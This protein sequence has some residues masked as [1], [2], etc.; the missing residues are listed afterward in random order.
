MKKVTEPLSYKEFEQRVY[1]YTYPFVIETVEKFFKEHQR[2]LKWL[3]P[4][5]LVLGILLLP[6]F[7]IGIAFIVLYWSSSSLLITELK[8]QLKPNHIYKNIFDSISEDFE[9]ISAQNSGDLD[10]RDYPIASYGVPVMAFKSIVQRSPEFNIRYRENLFSIR[11]LTYEWVETVGKVE[12]RRRQEVAIAKMLMKPNELSDFDF[13]WFQKSLFTRSQN[14][15]TENKQFNSVFAMKSNDP[16]KALMVATPYSMETLLKHYRNNIST[17]LLHLTK[18]RNTFKISF[19]VSLKGFLILN[20]QVTNNHEVVVRNILG[21]IMGDMYEL[22]SIIALM[23]IPP[24]L[25]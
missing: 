6:V 8:R 15:Q 22:Y 19:A 10:P 12:T 3:N 25:D 16:I 21:D 1:R 23:A 14:I 17:N 11:S 4:G 5:W 20:Y 13:T 9:F 24:M 7:F 2:Q 18:N